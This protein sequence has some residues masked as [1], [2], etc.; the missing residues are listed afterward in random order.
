MTDN[1]QH[2]T[3]PAYGTGDAT[4]QAAGGIEGITALVDRFY[5]LMGTLPEAATL[6]AMHPEDLSGSKRKLAYFLSGWMGGPKL[7]KEHF[8][9][10]T[11]P[12]AHKHFPVDMQSKE[13]WL[14]CMERAL[15]ELDYPEAFRRY[16]MKQ[17]AVPAEV[18][19]ARAEMEA[20]NRS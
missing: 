8:G 5:A 16:L 12:E 10:I 19:R 1:T 20:R 4:Y 9:P 15:I 6:R 17:L 7:F 3:A 2:D 18:I 14:L 13:A 11:I